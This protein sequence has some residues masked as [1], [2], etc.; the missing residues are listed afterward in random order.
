[1]LNIE[2]IKK[3]REETGISIALCK[4]ALEQSDNDL[5]KAKK[6]LSKWGVEKVK[7]K[8]QRATPQGAIFSYVH[9]NY[10]IASLVELLCETDFVAANKEFQTLGKEI[11]LQVVSLPAKS[12]DEILK[13]EYIRDPSKKIVDLI[14]EAIVKFGENIKIGR[15]TR[16]ELGNYYGKYNY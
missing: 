10:K 7:D 1:M 4:K 6:L 8:S 2:K 14:N 3:L 12:V 16:L 9:H 13:Q 11:S 15:F 5:P